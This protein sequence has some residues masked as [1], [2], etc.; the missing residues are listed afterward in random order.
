MRTLYR[1]GRVYSPADPFATALLV[2]GAT[3]AWLGTDDAALAIDADEQVDLHD[4]FLTPAFVDAHVHAT[5]AGLALTALDLSD[6]RT[7]TEALNRVERY[8]RASRGRPVIG[9]GW[10]DSQWPEGRPPSRAELDRAGYGGVVYLARV[11]VHSAAVSSSLAASIGGLHALPGYSAELLSLQAHHAARAAAFTTL[12]PGHIRDA[13]R[14]TRRRAAELGIGSLHEMAGPEVSSEEDLT[15]LLAL[16]KSEPGPD[17]LAY[18]GELLEV[19]KARSLGAIG[20]GGDLFCDGSLGSHT[21]ALTSS[22]FDDPAQIGDLRFGT[23]ELV[24]HL[25]ACARRGMQAGFHAIGDAAIDQLLTAVEL[26]SEKLGR[27]AGAG[28]RVEHAE[29]IS[30]PDRFARAGFTASMQPLFDSTW[31]G[32]DGM[33]AKRL[34]SARAAGLNRFAALASAGVPLAFGSDA[35]VTAMGPWASVR[36]AAHP[37]NTT[38]AIS[39]RS[40]FAAHTR[41]GWR[42]AR[43]PDEGVLSTGAPAT[44]AVWNAGEVGVDSPDDRV[45]R[46]STDPRAAVPGLPDLSP[47]VELPTCLRTV[48]RGQTIFDSSVS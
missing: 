23:D 22:Y 19:D 35:P 27:L 3:I 39:P 30:D 8:S 18:W 11:D 21:A 1:N 43:R 26:A 33:Y 15:A 45:T 32:E 24:E 29:M 34:G 25:L 4:A 12:T 9:G 47:G 20:A 6:A 36:A 14:A 7:L 31:G 13:Q 41:G 16:S 17:V 42:A 37:H 38:S 5:S 44:F 48:V 40:A 10:D 28:H 46:W 2:D